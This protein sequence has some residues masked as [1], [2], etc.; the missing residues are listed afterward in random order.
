MKKF[1]FC[2]IIAVR[3]TAEI[4]GVFF[5]GC[6]IA[7]ASDA[8]THQ[9]IKVWALLTIPVYAG[10]LFAMSRFVTIRRYEK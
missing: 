1:L 3:L 6:V 9:F 7:Y 5:G 4:L 10:L 2:L 8:L